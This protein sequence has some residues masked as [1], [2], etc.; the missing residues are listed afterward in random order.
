[1]QLTLLDILWVDHYLC[2]VL[3]LAFISWLLQI[4]V[5]DDISLDIYVLAFNS[6]SKLDIPLTCR[7][8]EWYVVES[9]A[10]HF[11]TP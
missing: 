6:I 5:F 11:A 10:L 8:F 9:S 4:F 7:M 2:A 3:I 1:M